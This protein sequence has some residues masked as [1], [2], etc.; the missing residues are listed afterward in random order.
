MSFPRAKSPEQL[1]DDV[2]DYDLVITPD[3]PL[4][5]ALNRQ[6]D[7]PHLGPFAIP[8][9]R[10]AAG[11]REKAED[12]LAFLELVEQDDVSWK[13]AAYAIG[14]I[15]QC[16]E[17][18]GTH[19][20]IHEYDAYVDDATTDAVDRIAE[21]DTT[22]ME[23]TTT[24]I[25]ADQRVAVV[26]PEMLTALEHSFLP[27]EYDAVDLF[28][29]EPF[30]RPPFHIFDSPTAIVD[31]VVDAITEE[32]AEDVGIVLDQASEFSPLVES[33]LEAAD[34]P[35]FGGP[36]F[37]DSHEHRTFLQLLRTA[38]RG[39]DTRVSE[40]RPLLAT[41]DIDLDI[42]HEEK[43]LYELSTPEIDWLTEFCEGVEQRSFADTLSAFEARAN[44]DLEAFHEELETLG[45]ATDP[46]TERGVDQ[47]AFYLQSYDVPVDRENEGVLLADAKSASYVGRDVVFFL[48]LDEDW[49][50]SA[51]RRP[52]VDKEAQYTR[53]IQGFQLL[54]QS[55][56]S[57]HYLVQDS[58]GGSPVTP[59]LYFKELLDTEYERFR[60]LESVSHTRSAT[61]SETQTAFE[62]SAVDTTADTVE[63]V[64]QSSL[65]TYVNSPRDYYFSKLVDNPQKDYFAEGNLFHDFAEFYVNHPA[66]V[67]DTVI[68][69][70]VDLMLDEMRPLVR[71][72]DE[73]T[74]RTEYR[75]GLE[76]IVSYLESNPPIDGAFLTPASG[77]GTNVVADHFDKDVDSPVTERWFEDD[78]LGVKGKI[79]LVH[80]RDELFDFKSGSQ[81]SA[82]EVVKHSAIEEPTDTPNYQALLYLTYWRSNYPDQ[83]LAFTFF[84]FLDPVDDVI[85]GDA[86][87]EDAV[88]TVTYYPT[89]L[90]DHVR[91]ESFFEYLRED[92]AGDCRK[93][94]SKID[95]ETYASLFETEP[96]PETADYDEIIDSAFGQQMIVDLRGVVGKYKYVTTG[97]EQAMR[98]IAR[99]YGQNYFRG[100]LDAFETFLDE[101]LTELNRRHAGEE[102][103]PIEGL[104]GEPN[105]RRVDNRDLLLEGER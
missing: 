20:A 30:E 17:H 37:A 39:T 23:L 79:D 85:T 10:L 90:T 56:S 105:Y 1:Y 99:T 46:V 89:S 19:D 35:F 9:R 50:H 87:L 93:T 96:L 64:S 3:G 6:L 40:I 69:T 101:R 51:P 103:F 33:A 53:N 94:L 14:N 59:C 27:D 92:G 84:H 86:D 57:H 78:D 16:W 68:E 49:T 11:R 63:T 22:S 5:S 36:G 82:R 25:D 44:C 91:S 15:L 21:L 7:R 74:R 2:A 98:E 41:L 31:A 32:N 26:A 12:R 83:E 48:G 43:R 104:A 73:E 72:V 24:Q 47:L 55:G 18:Q 81:K 67:D 54:L 71:S 76:T 77:S 88:T 42:S 13:R 102:R 28:T 100:D 58:A 38:H 95:Y 61:E 8:P 52:W 60:D 34:V 75:I 45:I 97:C 4:A 66:F 29:D 62:R 70:V 65:N 80:S